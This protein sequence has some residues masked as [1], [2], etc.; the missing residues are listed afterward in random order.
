MLDYRGNNINDWS[1]NEKR[2]NKD[3]ESPVGWIGIGLRVMDYYGD[4][5]W[6]GKN[7]D[8]GEWNVA[9]HAVGAGQS[10]DNIKKIIGLACK[11]TLKPGFRQMHANCDDIN[12]P[13]KKVGNGVYITP[14][15]SNAEAYAGIIEIN[16]IKYK[17]V[18]MLRVKP[19]SIRKCN[20]QSGFW[21][22]NGTIDEIRIYRIL[23]KK[24]N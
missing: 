21:V 15:I 19:E 1:R 7:N 20:C 10:S 3:Y 12:H 8:N 13:G 17:T 11:T 18:L 4:N 5:A 6:L 24:C 22:V 16:D 23:F 2:G 9:Y 14:S